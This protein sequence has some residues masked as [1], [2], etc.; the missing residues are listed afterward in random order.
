[1]AIIIHAG[2]LRAFSLTRAQG[3]RQVEMFWAF[4]EGDQLICFALMLNIL[5]GLTLK[6]SL[7]SARILKAGNFQVLG[8]EEK[9]YIRTLGCLTS[10]CSRER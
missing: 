3:L 1:M 10:C 6:C 2:H 8:T 5:L 4:I 9:E 7:K